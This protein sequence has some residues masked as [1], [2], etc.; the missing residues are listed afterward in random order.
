M[1]QP[2]SATARPASPL[3]EEGGQDDQV[4]T[5]KGRE[6]ARSPSP[7]CHEHKSEVS[8]RALAVEFAAGPPF[9]IITAIEQPLAAPAVATTAGLGR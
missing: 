5:E 4:E 6:T 9:A 3:R 8:V 2:Y 1:P 7:V